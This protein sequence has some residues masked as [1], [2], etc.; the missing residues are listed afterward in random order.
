MDIHTLDG[1]SIATRER[2]VYAF[3]CILS[4]TV[5]IQASVATSV[6]SMHISITLLESRI[7]SQY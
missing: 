2:L 1:I 3:I 5:S 4:S 7:T 6:Q